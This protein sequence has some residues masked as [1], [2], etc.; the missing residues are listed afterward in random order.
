MPMYGLANS[1]RWWL[2]ALMTATLAS[3]L[4]A[5]GVYKWTDE[6]GRTH[7]GD[8]PLGGDS[9]PIDVKPAPLAEDP[10]S[11]ERRERS[12]KLLDE[13]AESRAE[14]AAADTKAR[15]ESAQRQAACAEARDRLYDYEHAGYI[16]ETDEHGNR[17]ILNDAEHAQALAASREAVTQ[18][19]R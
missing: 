19:C 12:R 16:Y 9:R 15:E 6:K 14:K 8:R 2:G 3:P 11:S 1:G 5:E 17:R 18:S 7:Y 10:A 13:L 4:A